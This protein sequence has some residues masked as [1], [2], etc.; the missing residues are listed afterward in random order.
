[1]VDPRHYWLVMPAAGAGRRFG[2]SNP[3][4]Y[5]PLAG[6]TVL[7]VA[8]EP[9]LVDLRCQGIVLAVPAAELPATR[10]RWSGQERMRAVAGG[11]RRCDSVLAGL[12]ALLQQA[13]PGATVLVH[14]AARPC[15]SGDDLDRLLAAGHGLEDGALLA[16]PVS[17][18]IKREGA[19][20][21]SSGT[22][23]RNGLWRALTPQ[24][25]PLGRLHAALAAAL[26]RGDA[27]TDEAQALEWAGARPLLVA[28]SGANPKI[29]TAGDL[30]LA[31]ALL[32]H[33][34]TG[35]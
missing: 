35:A 10:D 29:T 19:D 24:M 22:V 5:A 9:F 17:D 1:V 25:A 23:E 18:T 6:R 21:R 16:A 14:D 13:P 2:G 15:L 7:E 12:A 11:E 20:G 4:Q 30:P 27:P 28:A 26:A 31:E 3:K 34:A 8:L 32:A 33:R